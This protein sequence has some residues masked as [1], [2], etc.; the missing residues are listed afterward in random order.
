MTDVREL[1]ADEARGLL[2]RHCGPDVVSRTE[3]EGWSEKLWMQLE[4]ADL[5]RVGLAE[6]LGGA[7]GGLPE[8]AA[9]VS[10]AA[11]FAAPV[12]LAE[13]CLLGGWLL[14]EAG[15][16]IP[17]G[18]ISAGQARDGVAEVPYGRSANAIAIL[19]EEGDAWQ[20]AR[21][22]PGDYTIDEGANLAG[23]SRD[24]VRIRR[25]A[26]ARAAPA[27]IDA[28]A[29]E[30]RGALARSVQMAGALDRLAALT[31]EYAGQR[32]QFGSP[33]VRFQA[34]QALLV[35]AAQEAA[36]ARAAVDAAVR[37]PTRYRI[38]AAKV[39]AGEAAGAAAEMA[40]QVHG[41]IGFTHEHQLHHFTRRLWSWREEYG[42]EARWA[43]VLGEQV[44][45][46][47]ADQ[48]WRLIASE[49]DL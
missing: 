24:T 18:P 37:A 34:V 17:L 48:T 40:H 1:L 32:E 30:A 4:R 15:F 49:G 26:D 11:S 16:S 8:A 36:A 42:G 28:F 9:V 41:A 19:F 43:T 13:T 23:E 10:A 44:L 27:G 46:A 12:P 33:I 35:G 31:A 29:F 3:A 7:G 20:V 22:Q 14:Q 2:E 38:A 45:E 5:C 47:G 21:L 25:L 6:E 39:R